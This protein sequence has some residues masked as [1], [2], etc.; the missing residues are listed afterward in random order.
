MKFAAGL[1]VTGLMLVTFGCVA[2]RE[3]RTSIAP[4]YSYVEA[5]PD[6]PATSAWPVP[7]SHADR[8]AKLPPL[9]AAPGFQERLRVE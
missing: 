2:Q 1:A 4:T 5:A 8:V 6:T 9:P 3:P 7:H